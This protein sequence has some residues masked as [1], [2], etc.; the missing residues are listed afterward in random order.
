MFRV[1]IILLSISVRLTCADGPVRMHKPTLIVL[2]F[3]FYPKQEQKSSNEIT[4]YFVIFFFL[5]CFDS[6]ITL[7]WEPHKYL[8]LAS[9]FAFSEENIDSPRGN[10]EVFCSIASLTKIIYVY[11]FLTYS[12]VF[13][14]TYAVSETLSTNG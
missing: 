5:L 10:Y 9:S 8:S 7:V 6:H 2:I 12:V 13:A 1:V 11:T 14:N 4:V 3:C